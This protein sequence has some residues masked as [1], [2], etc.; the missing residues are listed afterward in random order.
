MSLIIRVEV[1]HCVEGSFL[2]RVIEEGK[3]S[4]NEE[5]ISDKP[6]QKNWSSNKSDHTKTKTKKHCLAVYGRTGIQKD[7]G[8]ALSL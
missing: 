5:Q 8:N 6:D 4:T 2:A 7:R 3:M 1:V